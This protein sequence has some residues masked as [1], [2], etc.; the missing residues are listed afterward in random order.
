MQKPLVV[1]L[2]LL[3]SA[4]ASAFS[5]GLSEHKQIQHVVLCWMAEGHSAEDVAAV[6]A[7]FQAFSSIPQIASLVIGDALPSERAI[8]DDS[9]HVG[10]V[11]EFETA[12]DLEAFMVDRS[13]KQITTEVL[14]PLCPRA[15]VYD[16]Y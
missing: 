2:L 5:S 16:I 7:G 6:K 4:S 8:V 15:V 10:V 11:M 12:D 13:H 14:A 3:S 9:F 1:A